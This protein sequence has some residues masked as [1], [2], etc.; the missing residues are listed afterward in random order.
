MTRF[1]LIRDIDVT[2]VSGEGRVAEGVRFTD[3]SVALRWRGPYASTAV[4]D[5]IDDVLAVHGHNGSTRVEWIDEP[6]RVVLS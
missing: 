1:W 3:G 5:G 2:G 6:A 4:W